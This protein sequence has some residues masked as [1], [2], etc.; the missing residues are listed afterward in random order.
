VNESSDAID[1]LTLIGQAIAQ[2]QRCIEHFEEAD[3]GTGISCLSTVISDIDAYLDR[4]GED[5]LVSLAHVD[6]ARLQESLHHVQ[7]DLSAVIKQ[8]ERPPAPVG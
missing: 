2:L 3:Q 4:L 5:P 7:E 6:P 8:I 1:L